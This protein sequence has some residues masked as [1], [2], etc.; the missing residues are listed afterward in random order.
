MDAKKMR[1]MTDSNGN[2][3]PVKYISAYDK[4]RDAT[5]RKVYARFVKAR[6]AL[7]AVV[8]DSIRQ[9]Y[10]I[11]LDERV[12]RA[13]EL[14]LEYVNSIRYIINGPIHTRETDL[15]RDYYANVPFKVEVR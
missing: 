12:V 13:R 6:K 5:V 14:M 1:T 8:A 2:E 10:N 15:P 4:Q 3:V 7:E 11:L 9:Q